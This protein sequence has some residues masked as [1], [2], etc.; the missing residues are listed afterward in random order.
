VEFRSL[1]YQTVDPT[2]TRVNNHQLSISLM[3][4]ETMK[5]HFLIKLDTR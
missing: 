5:R 3:I 1:I 2:R 4:Y